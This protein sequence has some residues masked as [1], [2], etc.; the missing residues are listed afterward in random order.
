MKTIEEFIFS[1]CQCKS[2]G[3]EAIKANPSIKRGDNQW[4][5][6]IFALM[7]AVDEYIPTPE[8]DTEKTFLMAI[9][10]DLMGWRL[11]K[12]VGKSRRFLTVD[13]AHLNP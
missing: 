4:V 11:G 7:D 3:I 1:A 8:R 5:D 12:S 6:K 9:E 2:K 13:Q 10:D